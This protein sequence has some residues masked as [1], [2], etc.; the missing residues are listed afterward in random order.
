MP[1][2]ALAPRVADADLRPQ[3]L[4]VFIGS[5]GDATVA[6]GRIK[7]VDIDNYVRNVITEPMKTLL[8]TVKADKCCA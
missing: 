5:S 8:D 2:T 4:D 7:S 1:A 3:L 6:V